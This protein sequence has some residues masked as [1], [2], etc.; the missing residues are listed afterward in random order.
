MYLF[1]CSNLFIYLV[2]VLVHYYEH[3]SFAS[4][5][6][7]NLIIGLKVIHSNNASAIDIYYV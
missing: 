2:L 1:K 7:S 6:A 4:R 3:N 5:G